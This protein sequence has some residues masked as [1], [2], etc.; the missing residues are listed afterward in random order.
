MFYRVDTRC[1]EF[2]INLKLCDAIAPNLDDVEYPYKIYSTTHNYE[3]KQSPQEI[4][5]A[6]RKFHTQSGWDDK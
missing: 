6:I 2:W 3:I 4:N 1:G 5:N